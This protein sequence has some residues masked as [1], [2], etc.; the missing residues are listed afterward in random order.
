MV[1]FIGMFLSGFHL[2]EGFGLVDIGGVLCKDA[3]GLYVSAVVGCNEYIAGVNNSVVHI[4][5]LLDF[6][7][8]VDREK[9]DGDCSG[10]AGI[11]TDVLLARPPAEILDSTGIGL[12]L[13]LY[14]NGLAEERVEI[15]HS[16]A[17]ELVS[18]VV[19]FFFIA[20]VRTDGGGEFSYDYTL[21]IQIYKN[22]SFYLLK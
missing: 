8:V 9:V 7:D 2:D 1:D 12:S 11:Q 17:Q 16:V 15:F 14:L 20:V 3:V 13:G 19:D 22:F 4:V 10:G 21:T 5:L 18:A 6:L